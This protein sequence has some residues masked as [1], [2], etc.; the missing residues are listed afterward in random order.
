MTTRLYKSLVGG[1]LRVAV[2]VRERNRKE[3]TELKAFR[4]TYLQPQSRSRRDLVGPE[5]PLVRQ[6]C[7]ERRLVPHH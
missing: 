5:L 6:R 2:G 1:V 7:L 3:G 4:R